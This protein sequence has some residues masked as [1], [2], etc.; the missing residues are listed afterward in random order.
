[1]SYRWNLSF[2][3]LAIIY[4]VISNVKI[5]VNEE[6]LVIKSVA[7]NEIVIK[8]VDSVDKSPGDPK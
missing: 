6:K 8:S 5:D 1:M 2:R 3:Y 4:D 7:M